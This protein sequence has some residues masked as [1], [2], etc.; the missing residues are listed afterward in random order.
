MEPLISSSVKFG[1]QRATFCAP[2]LEPARSPPPSS[3]TKALP[4]VPLCPPI[5]R[6]SKE[7]WASQT[8]SYAYALSHP[9]LGQAW[10][11]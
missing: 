9:V 7:V 8:R 4:G 10:E 11:Q 6:Y 1:G 5:I 3:L 2:G